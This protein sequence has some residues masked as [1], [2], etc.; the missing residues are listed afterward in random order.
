ML[1]PLLKI[2]LHYSASDRARKVRNKNLKIKKRFEKSMKKSVKNQQ[3]EKDQSP[4]KKE[5]KKKALKNQ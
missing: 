4:Q 5:F 1:Y 2:P 3:K